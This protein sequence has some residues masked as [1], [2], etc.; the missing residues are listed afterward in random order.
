MTSL[1]GTAKAALSPETSQLL[2]ESF[3]FTQTTVYENSFTWGAFLYLFF[4]QILVEKRS[5][6]VTWLEEA[7]RGVFTETVS[8]EITRIWYFCS[9]PFSFQMEHKRKQLTKG[10]KAIHVCPTWLQVFKNKLNWKKQCTVLVM[11]TNCCLLSALLSVQKLHLH[12]LLTNCLECN[13]TNTSTQL[14]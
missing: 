14:I 11:S 3:G 10:E 7:R 2:P 4:W 13:S 8:R 6:E 5:L 9:W 1:T 12:R